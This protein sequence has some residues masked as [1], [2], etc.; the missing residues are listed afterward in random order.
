MSNGHV[1][2]LGSA[3]VLATQACFPGFL[4]DGSVYCDVS[5]SCWMALPGKC[6][7]KS[8]LGEEVRVVWLFPLFFSCP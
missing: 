6:L 4:A 7:T 1:L 3:M 5:E 8:K 2:L